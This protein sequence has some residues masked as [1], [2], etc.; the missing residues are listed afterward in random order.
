MD[1]FYVVV[2]TSEFWVAVAGA[3]V[4][5]LVNFGV[6]D[7]NAADFVSMGV[8]YIFGRLFSKAAKATF[9]NGGSK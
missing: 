2:R 1:K 5:V 6:L 7:K 3:L 4:T 8:V 9:P